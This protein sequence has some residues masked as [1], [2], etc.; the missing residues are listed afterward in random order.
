MRGH[1]PG[2]RQRRHQVDIKDDLV[3]ARWQKLVWNVP[4]SGLSVVLDADTQA[5]MA[6]PHTRA[7]AEDIMGEVVAGARACGRHIHDNFARKMIDMTLAM[8]PTGPA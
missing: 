4:M 2:L 6:D 8:P 3:L 1:R 5:L 7:L